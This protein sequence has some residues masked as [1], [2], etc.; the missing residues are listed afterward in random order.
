MT[1]RNLIP[2]PSP[3]G[4]ADGLDYR[5]KVALLVGCN[6]Y[7]PPWPPL[8]NAVRD[9]EAVGRVLREQYGFDVFQIS[10]PTRVG[11]LS[12]IAKLS[13]LPGPRGDDLFV[14]LFAGHGAREQPYLVP[15]DA[16]AQGINQ[17]GYA[18]LLDRIDGLGFQHSLVLLD[19]CY[20]GFL[21]GGMRG[22]GLGHT[23]SRPSLLQSP[24]AGG[25]RG[26]VPA[27]APR[28]LNTI[29]AGTA[30]EPVSDGLPGTHSPFVTALL[31]AFAEHE[32]GRVISSTA[33]FVFLQQHIASQSLTSPPT[34]CFA[35]RVMGM[36]DVML[37]RPGV[38]DWIRLATT[39]LPVAEV[40]RRYAASVHARGGTPPYRFECS[41]L[42]PGIHCEDGGALTGIPETQG[43]WQ[44]E[45]RIE[46]VHGRIGRGSLFLQVDPVD[47]ESV[48]PRIETDTLPPL[49]VDRADPYE[50]VFRV[51][52]GSLPM[53]WKLTGLPD[54]LVTEHADD[55]SLRVSGHAKGG[56]PGGA[57]VVEAQVR[58]R[59]GV[60]SRLP[61]PLPLPRVRSADY[62]RIDAGPF[63]AGYHSTRERDR[64]VHTLHAR[65]DDCPSVAALMAEYPPR[66]EDLPAY[67][68]KRTPVTNA[69]Y[70]EFVDATGHPPPRHWEGGERWFPPTQDELPV[71]HVTFADAEA[72][73]AWRGT[74][75]PTAV[76]WEKAARGTD[77]RL[78][79]WGD[80]FEESLCNTSEGERR[81]LTAVDNFAD[82]A[83]PYG[84][85]DCCGN[86][87]EWTDGGSVQVTQDGVRLVVRRLR[88]GSFVDAGR[89]HGMVLVESAE[90]FGERLLDAP[91]GLS[92]REP[93]DYW[94]GFRDVVD[95]GEPAPRQAVVPIPGGP[96]VLGA[97]E[98]TVTVQEFAIARFA[99]SNLEYH[100]FVAATGHRRPRHWAESDPPF[101]YR[102]RHWPVVEVSQS[103]AKAFCRW[104]GSV[105]G[106]WH[107]LPTGSQWERAVRGLRDTAA[108]GPYPW[109]RQWE[110]WRCNHA[111]RGLGR[112]A[113]VFAF[114]GGDTVE[115]VRN[116]AG[117]CFEWVAEPG[118]SRGGCWRAEGCERS[119]RAAAQV[120]FDG[121]DARDG[122]TGFRYRC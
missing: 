10:N 45:Y 64:L 117:N 66:E 60:V 36:G 71:V 14:F 28:L 11:M 72:Y 94:I 83:S 26:F 55:G 61:W 13:E 1:E 67:F 104:K 47:G 7:E 29:T 17:I 38:G 73:C 46:D 75:L 118:M 96:I 16:G 89:L 6:E 74:R 86:V 12:E 84:V 15:I 97:E 98:R 111:E 92:L 110:G 43:C 114:A 119:G 25:P 48:T 116:L 8:H 90:R 95:L 70:R 57:A 99:V 82:G 63:R 103:D 18:E 115:G 31:A 77:G 56:G 49:F 40:G 87:A 107:G 2:E 52:G 32:P 22:A 81:E 88:G 112:P 121:H 101:P 9:A 5:R 4:T 51:R 39:A 50:A 108:A 93:Q 59:H 58:D 53:S 79:P 122:E 44:L 102:E 42:P 69:E 106:R 23:V 27:D 30:L 113:A 100:E 21:M 76:E 62:A 41:A 33:L 85:L 34:P 3:R 54:G 78:F 109:G 20:S 37:V 120:R 91:E 105:T 35:Q 65:Y 19:C 24:S 68:M 80:D